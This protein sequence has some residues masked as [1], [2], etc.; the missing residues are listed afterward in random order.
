M[1]DEMRVSVERPLAPRGRGRRAVAVLILAAAPVAGFAGYVA[2][3]YGSLPAFAA[4]VR[5]EALYTPAAAARVEV[6]AGEPGRVTYQVRNVT[7]RAVTVHGAETSCGCFTPANLPLTIPPGGTAD[8][9]FVVKFPKQ[10]VG[11]KQHVTTWLY[12]DYSPPLALT[13]DITEVGA[14]G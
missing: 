9:A 2:A 14:R 5:G 4:G 6:T 12:L 11:R 7:G 8:I 1:T 10:D 13:A 3:A